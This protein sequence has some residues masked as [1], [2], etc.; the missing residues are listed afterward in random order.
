MN[1]NESID[2]LNKRIKEVYYA[3]KNHLN[4]RIYRGHSRSISTDIED[5]IALFIYDF[6]P[7]DYYLIVD[8]SVHVLGKTHRP[9]VLIVNGNNEVVALIE[10]KANMGWCRDARWVLNDII[11]DDKAY[12]QASTLI[13]KLSDDTKKEVSYGE[14]VAKFLVA[15]TSENSDEDKHNANKKYASSLGIRHYLLFSSW[16]H[17]LEKKD[18]GFFARD[19]IE[20]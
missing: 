1:I 17:S 6:I 7:N 14:N 19:I 9:D 12:N 5:A 20:L 16:Y 10:I 11:E 2:A 15:L 4:E 18:A 3:T 13:C 8:P